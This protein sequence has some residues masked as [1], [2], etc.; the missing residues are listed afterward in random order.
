M[1]IISW[2]ING[3]KAMI[4]KGLLDMMKILNA[5]F[6]LF[7]EIKTKDIPLPFKMNYFVYSFP[8]KE[9][10]YSGVMTLTKIKP[11]NV[12]Y[13]IGESK[14]D[15]EGRVLTLEYDS[16]Y[17]INVYFPNAGQDTL[18]R[19][20]FKLEFDKK[21]EEFVL[22]L[23]KPCIICGDFNVAHKEIDIYD[24]NRF[25]RYAGFTD[26]ERQWFDHFLSLGFIDTFRYIKGNI[27]KYSWFPYFIEARKKN[28]GWRIDYC[29]VSKDIIDKV[30][31][32][33]ILYDF[34]GSDHLPVV[35]EIIL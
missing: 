22:S 27:I 12:I 31:D 34:Y 18:K 25:R 14:F 6:Y 8:A 2:N 13:G 17:L 21:F 23:K 30:K 9:K 7:Q 16:F 24:P 19:L 26:E 28:L 32:A 11:L 29:V 4:K 20:D 35:L 15:D 33:D 5:D 1:K 3:L 10:G